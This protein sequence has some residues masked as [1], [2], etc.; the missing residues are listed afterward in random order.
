MVVLVSVSC[1]DKLSSPS[2]AVDDNNETKL[3]VGSVNGTGSNIA[4]TANIPSEP[5][6]SINATSTP[7]IVQKK[8]P[9][10]S[11]SGMFHVLSKKGYCQISLVGTWKKGKI[12][13]K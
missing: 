4:Q 11:S 1:S 13:K 10:F 9:R 2:S 3:D 7:E 12:V 8:I 5:P 6:T